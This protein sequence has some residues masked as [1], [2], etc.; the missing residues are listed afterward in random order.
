MTVSAKY[1]VDTYIF[2]LD[3]RGKGEVVWTNS[4]SGG[5]PKAV[6]MRAKCG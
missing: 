6:L 1:L 2:Y 3:N 4:R 5:P